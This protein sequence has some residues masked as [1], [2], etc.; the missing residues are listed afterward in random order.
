MIK[1]SRLLMFAASL[2]LVSVIAGCSASSNVSGTTDTTAK[3]AKEKAYDPSGT[4][5]Y[6]VATPNGDSFGVMTITGSN[7]VYEAALET[8]QFGT[9]PV[10]NFSVVGNSFSGVLDVMGTVA[11]LS[12]N[13]DG[14]LMSGSVALGPDVYP[15]QGSRKAK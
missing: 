11:D 4:W 2:I 9:I 5:E 3:K 7:G 6:S 14:D 1:Y 10:T 8:D 15:L 13:F 12:G